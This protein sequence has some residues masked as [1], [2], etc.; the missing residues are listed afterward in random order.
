[1]R[2]LIS[3][4]RDLGRR[5]FVLDGLNEESFCGCR[6]PLFAEQGLDCL[7]LLIDCTIEVGP[8]NL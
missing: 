7:A 8:L 3:V 5:R 1:V 2:C 4:E 6:I